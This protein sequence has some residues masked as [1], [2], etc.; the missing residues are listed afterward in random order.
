MSVTY[1][2]SNKILDANFGAVS[3]SFPANF[4]V[5]LSASALNASGSGAVEPVGNA[6]ARVEVANSKSSFTTAASGSLS[7]SV[8]ITFPES[9]GS[10]G[11]MSYVFLSDSSSSASGNIWFYEALSSPKIIQTNTE[12]SFIVGAITISMQNA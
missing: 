4:Y 6:Y 7:N 10:W 2:A 5:G 9:S 3:Y 12:V 8:A 1:Y 11:T